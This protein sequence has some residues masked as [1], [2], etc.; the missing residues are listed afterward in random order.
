MYVFNRGYKKKYVYGGSGLLDKIFSKVLAPLTSQAISSGTKVLQNIDVGKISKDAGIKLG[1][2]AMN[3][4]TSKP[5]T[6]S[7]ITLKDY[8]EE[9]RR[10]RQ[11]KGSGINEPIPIESLV[12]RVKP[13]R[14]RRI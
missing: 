1:T 13:W 4:F 12:L 7:Q 14:K 5:K 2:K 8:L 10:M 9:G 6:Q 3:A 11:T